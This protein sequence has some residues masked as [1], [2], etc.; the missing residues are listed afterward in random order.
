MCW[1]HH[2]GTGVSHLALKESLACLGG[3]LQLGHTDG[4]LWSVICPIKVL[5][6]PVHCYALDSVDS[7]KDTSVSSMSDEITGSF[8]QYIFEI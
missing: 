2:Y 7:Y 1:V 5:T 8:F 6:H 4:L 3:F